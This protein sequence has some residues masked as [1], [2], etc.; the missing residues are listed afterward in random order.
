MVHE[1]FLR[2]LFRFLLHLF[3]LLDF[4]FEV[5]NLFF[6]RLDRPLSFVELSGL[7]ADSFGAPLEL[8][9]EISH[10]G[11][12]FHNFLLGILKLSNDSLDL[13]MVF[14]D[15]L[16]CKVDF[17]MSILQHLLCL[18]GQL[19]NSLDCRRRSSILSFVPIR[20]DCGLLLALEGILYLLK[21][22]IN[23]QRRVIS[24]VTRLQLRLRD[25]VN[26]HLYQ[27]L[28]LGLDV[29]LRVTQLFN[30]SIGLA[31]ELLF[32][33]ALLLDL[34]QSLLE[35]LRFLQFLF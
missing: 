25:I 34:L 9:L 33:C 30:G 14:H 4:I 17:L 2:L 18:R 1:L 16:V 3:A 35:L 20:E 32:V 23:G 27:V 29:M 19:R 12:V 15:H 31:D 13:R 21:A 7:I 10:A 5:A 26:I 11:L 28:E 24:F 8:G 6:E 22:P